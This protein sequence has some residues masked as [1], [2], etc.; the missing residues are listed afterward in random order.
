MNLP[1][2]LLKDGKMSQPQ[3]APQTKGSELKRAFMD[4]IFVVLLLIAAG[5]GGYTFGIAQKLGPITFVGPGT[6]GALPPLPSSSTP[7]AT[8]APATTPASSTTASSATS[9]STSAPS[10][11]AKNAKMKYWLTS[12]GE[13]YVGYSI[14]VKV[15]SE[16]VDN[17]F[18]PGKTVN[19]SRFIKPG[20]NGVTFEA[21]LLGPEYN[22]HQGDQGAVLVVQVV[23]GPEV[24]EDFKPSDVVAAFQKSATDNGDQTETKHFDAE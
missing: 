8:T 22:K 14:T 2:E 1:V 7:T 11:P 9:T 23:K 20:K 5:F 3:K 21:K 13:E 6:P 4:F 19:I 24:K 15:N 17:F 12:S 16:T 18:G 10:T